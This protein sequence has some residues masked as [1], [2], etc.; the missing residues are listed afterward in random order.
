MAGKT[1]K[2]AKIPFLSLLVGLLL[3]LSGCTMY[4]AA[5]FKYSEAEDGAEQEEAGLATDPLEVSS[6]AAEV[7]LAWDPP[8][9]AI[10]LYRV[11][12]RIHGTSS[13]YSLTDNLPAEPAPQ[14][15]VRHTDLD[16]G[17]FDFGVIAVNA[18]EAES[19]MHYS[20]ESTAQ[21]D[22]GWYLVWED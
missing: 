22:T 3:Y 20:L 1:V 17:I 6:S 19:S 13:W 21:P 2:A 16:S 18:E 4:M 14:F 7:T 5:A 11:L 9:S 10:V 8:P 12:F 15:T